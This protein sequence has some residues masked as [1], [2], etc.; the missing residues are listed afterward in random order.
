MWCA[1]DTCAMYMWYSCDTQMVYIWWHYLSTHLYGLLQTAFFVHTLLVWSPLSAFAPHRNDANSWNCQH[2]MA[3]RA[4]YHLYPFFSYLCTFVYTICTKTI[5]TKWHKED[6]PLIMT[7]L[8]I[9]DSSSCS[10]SPIALVACLS[11]CNSIRFLPYSRQSWE[12][13]LTPSSS[14]SL[15]PIDIGDLSHCNSSIRFLP[16][17]GRAESHHWLLIIL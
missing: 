6:F 4:A 10:L 13:S 2:K 17:Q 15:A 12:S 7:S 9:T 1:F 11:D 14:R 8:V 3:Q 16:I 5:N